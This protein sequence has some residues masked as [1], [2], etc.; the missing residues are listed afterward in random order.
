MPEKPVDG[1]AVRLAFH[2]IALDEAGKRGATLLSENSKARLRPKS[3]HI[4]SRLHLQHFAGDQPKG[5]V[6]TYDKNTGSPRSA[7][8]DET[9]TFN[10]FYSVELEDRIFDTSVEDVLAANESDAAPIYRKLIDGEFPKTN[11]LCKKEAVRETGGLRKFR[12]P[13]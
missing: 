13:N 8:P 11:Q 2:L 1:R 4:V 10:H 6:W 5:Q 12:T 7:I 3:H 9:A